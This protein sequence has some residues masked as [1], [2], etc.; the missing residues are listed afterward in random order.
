MCHNL[1]ITR[2]KSKIDKTFKESKTEVIGLVESYKTRAV[3]DNATRNFYAGNA[4][5]IDSKNEI[6][7]SQTDVRTNSN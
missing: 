5:T 1:C 4:K 3:S 6:E 7:F 2:D